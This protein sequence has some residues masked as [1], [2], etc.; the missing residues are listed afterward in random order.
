M[1][2]SHGSHLP[3]SAGGIPRYSRPGSD[4]LNKDGWARITS[5]SC[6]SAGKCAAG[7]LYTDRSG[8]QQGFVVSQT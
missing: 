4:T 6:R 7:G 2:S 1:G 5:V 3:G 8:H